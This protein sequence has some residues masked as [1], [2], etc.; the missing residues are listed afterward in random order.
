M[1]VKLLDLKTIVLYG[2]NTVFMGS[3]LINSTK[4]TY[5]LMELKKQSPCV[6]KANGGEQ[7]VRGCQSMSAEEERKVRSQKVALLPV[8]SSTGAQRAKEMATGFWLN[9]HH[10]SPVSQPLFKNILMHT[11]FQDRPF[12]C[13]SVC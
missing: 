11:F 9:A 12:S 10:D 1:A 4:Q 5:P 2:C 13:C 3:S 8:C 7:D 6:Y